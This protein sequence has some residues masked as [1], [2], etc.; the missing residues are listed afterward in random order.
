M[1]PLF[2]L[3]FVPFLIGGKKKHASTLTREGLLRTGFSE[4]D[5]RRIL[6]VQPIV[7]EMSSKYQ[8]DPQDVN[9]V[10]WIESRFRPDAISSVGA[11]GYMQLMPATAKYI[12]GI[13]GKTGDV[14]EPRFNIEIGTAYLKRLLHNFDDRWDVALGAYNWGSGNVR[15]VDDDVSRFPSSV[16]H[17]IEVV[18]EAG[19]R[20]KEAQ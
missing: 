18:I 4:D 6:L 19:N 3:L 8:M 15:N 9:G 5:I 14:A 10:I 7:S 11:R 13:L 1:D 12:A 16:Q 20:F 2:L 17:Y